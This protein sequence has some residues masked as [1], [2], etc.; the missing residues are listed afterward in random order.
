MAERP[1]LHDEMLEQTMAYY[2][3]DLSPEE[4]AEFEKH[5]AT[6]PGC[7]ES[8]RLAKTALPVVNKLLAIPRKRSIDEQ[9]ARFE[10]MVEEKRRKERRALSSR[11]RLWIGIAFGTAAAAAATFAILRLG[12]HIVLPGEVYAPP[13]PA[14]RPDAGPDAGPDGG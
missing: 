9:V 2:G 7:Q 3:G 10:A 12:P 8:L 1:P 13:K 11:R 5:L 6:C 4:A 14:A